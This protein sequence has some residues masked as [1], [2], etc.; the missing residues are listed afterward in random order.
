MIRSRP[1]VVGLGGTTRPGSTSEKALAL[2]LASAERAG[3]E[4]RMFAGKDL[5][6]PIYDPGPDALTGLAADLVACLR[7][8]DGVILSSPCYH[9]GVSGLVK[10]AI[11][12][13][14]EMRDDER[15]YFDGRAVGAIGCGYGF[16][17]P[18]L[19]LSQLRQITHALRGWPVPMGVAINSAVVGFGPDGCS[20]PAIGKQLD[21][22][23]DQVV[24]FAG[25]M[26]ERRAKARAATD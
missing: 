3:A 26:Q 7:R 13:A 16:Q 1:F 10:N 15:V 14:E 8:S 9:G 19:V 21:I 2:A 12:Y 20:E 17:G 11:D 25:M 22:M 24:Q 5:L 23:A 4:V 6:L 18:G